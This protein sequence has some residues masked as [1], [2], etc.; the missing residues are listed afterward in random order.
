ML[1]VPLLY[2]ADGLRSPAEGAEPSEQV[3]LDVLAG[4]FGEQHVH[5][6][7]EARVVGGST[8][9]ETAIAEHVADDV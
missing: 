8:D 7:V 2:L 4:Q 5:L 1:V 3:V 6:V 9:D